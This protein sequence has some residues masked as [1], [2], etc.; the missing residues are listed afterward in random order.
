MEIT[1]GKF[2]EQLSVFDDDCVLFF[3]GLDFYRLKLRGDKLL[4]VEFNQPVYLD[5]KGHVVVENI[6]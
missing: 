6:E 2:K 4:Q 1:V 3:G 5:K